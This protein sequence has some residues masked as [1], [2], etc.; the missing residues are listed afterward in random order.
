VVS[1][2]SWTREFGVFQNV[3][4][5]SG[6]HSLPSSGIMPTGGFCGEVN[7]AGAKHTTQSSAQVK[8][9]WNK[10]IFLP[11]MRP[12]GAQRDKSAFKMKHNIL[13]ILRL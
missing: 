13:N 5:A 11:S 4:T 1:L 10:N 6:T 2:P 8:N 12:D 3:Q 7:Q 9:N